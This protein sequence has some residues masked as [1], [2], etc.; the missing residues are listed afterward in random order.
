MAKAVQPPTEVSAAAKGPGDGDIPRDAEGNPT[1]VCDM[2]TCKEGWRATQDLAFIIDALI[3]THRHRQPLPT[4]LNDAAISLLTEQRANGCTT[5]ATTRSAHFWRWTAVR[6]GHYG[7]GLPWE[8]ACEF[9]AEELKDT[10]AAGVSGTMWSSYK[11]VMKDL[12]AGRAGIYLWPPS[13]T[14]P[15]DAN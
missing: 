9:A 2:M 6:D 7:K 13:L 12:R 15:P 3:L 1:Y 10:H 14:S 8:K 11:K 5:N 4:W